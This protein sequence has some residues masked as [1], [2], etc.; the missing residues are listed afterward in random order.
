M[1]HPA[2]SPAWDEERVKRV[3][4]HYEQQSEEVAVAE[5]EAPFENNG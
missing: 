3:L 4:G 1:S 2:Y 5:D